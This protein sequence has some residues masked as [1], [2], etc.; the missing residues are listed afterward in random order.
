LFSVVFTPPSPS[1]HGSVWFLHVISLLLNIT[2][3]VG[4]GL[5]I[6]MIG[7]VS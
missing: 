1:H 7:E 6:H 4:A 2:R 3:I 5:S